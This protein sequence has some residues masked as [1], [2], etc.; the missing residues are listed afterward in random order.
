MNGTFKSSKTGDIVPPEEQ[1][2]YVLSHLGLA[3]VAEKEE[4]EETIKALI[5]WYF[6]GMEWHEIDEEDEEQVHG[7]SAYDDYISVLE[8][9][10]VEKYYRRKNVNA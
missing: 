9:E 4:T 3:V 1:R 8:D 5:D 7:N 6:Q 2:E 10:A